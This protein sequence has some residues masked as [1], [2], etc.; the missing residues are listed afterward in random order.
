METWLPIVS[1]TLSI[2]VTAM[3]AFAQRRQNHR[4]NS[5][6]AVLA[7]ELEVYKS[8]RTAEI[9]GYRSMIEQ[10]LA[11]TLDGIVALQSLK[12]VAGDIAETLD[13]GGP[14]PRTAAILELQDGCKAV[15]K[16][17]KQLT[18][19]FTPQQLLPVHR[20]KG[21][22]RTLKAQAGAELKG[23]G[24]GGSVS[25]AFRDDLKE[26]RELASQAQDVLRRYADN[27]RRLLNQ[28]SRHA[29]LALD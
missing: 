12:D 15:E 26:I 7:S 11:Q 5:R 13:E 27:D 22:G 3:V 17:H 29:P 14:L 6:M 8:V 10:K 19:W 2:A 16:A 1:A 28:G 25:P 4:F 21:K 18:P 20:C 9:S 24:A 23:E